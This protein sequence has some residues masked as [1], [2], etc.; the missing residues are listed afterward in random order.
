MF[1]LII[2]ILNLEAE[3]NLP[4]DYANLPLFFFYPAVTSPVNCEV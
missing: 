3:L 1:L 4:K 2:C